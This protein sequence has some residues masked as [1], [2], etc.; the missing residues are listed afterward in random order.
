MMLVLAGS[1]VSAFTSNNAPAGFNIAALFVVVSR[2]APLRRG[3]SA[4]QWRRT[5]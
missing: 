3:I 4:A 1:A 2:L 5:P